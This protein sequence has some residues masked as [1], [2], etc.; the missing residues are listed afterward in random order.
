M[1][2]EKEE[3]AQYQSLQHEEVVESDDDPISPKHK[4]NWP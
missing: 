4:R 2:N 3:H 1:D